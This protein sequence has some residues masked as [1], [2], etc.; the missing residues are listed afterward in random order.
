MLGLH[1]D[2]VITVALPEFL[3][4]LRNWPAKTVKNITRKSRRKS[5]RK[6][7]GKPR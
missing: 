2:K 3:K 4:A 7:R 6:P 5:R 1:N